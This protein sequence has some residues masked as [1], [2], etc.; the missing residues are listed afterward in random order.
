[1]RREEYGREDFDEE[2]PREM[3]LKKSKISKPSILM[4]G[5]KETSLG[6][7]SVFKLITLLLFII[8]IF[9]SRTNSTCNLYVSG[10]LLQVEKIIGLPLSPLKKLY[11]VEMGLDSMELFERASSKDYLAV[12]KLLSWGVDGDALNPQGDNLLISAVKEGDI[13]LAKLLLRSGVSVD[14]KNSENLSALQ[15]AI[16][17]DGIEFFELLSELDANLNI[18]DD[19][20]L[21]PLMQLAAKKDSSMLLA[22]LAKKPKMNLQDEQGQTALFHAASVDNLKAVELLIT[23]GSNPKITN[24]KG[25]TAAK[26]APPGG[27]VEKFFKERG[28]LD[29]S[30][31]KIASLVKQDE[32][33][34]SDAVRAEKILVIEEP[35]PEPKKIK[36][37][38]ELYE[39]VSKKDALTGVRA[40]SRP[41][42]VWKRKKD[43]TLESVE[44]VLRNF[45]DV[46]AKNVKARVRVP[47]GGFVDLSGPP[48]L[49]PYGEAKYSA[50][51]KKKITRNGKLRA[52]V[53]CDNCYR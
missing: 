7:G 9:V 49:P 6:I 29:N 45:G 14:A 12:S 36:S 16:E 18:R 35:R 15:Y 27:F 40:K 48:R 13:D 34:E 30:S 4:K 42:G 39:K 1:M 22:F 8:S 11:K 37:K 25:L 26:L 53:T 3:N 31:S 46:E 5:L 28:L 21:T 41:V 47:G 43:L 19:S 44:V 20:E 2:E 52:F 38:R 23:S 17:T 32:S 33:T 24:H 51:P 10:L 50:S